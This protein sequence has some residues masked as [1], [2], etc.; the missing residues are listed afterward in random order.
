MLEAQGAHKSIC[1]ILQLGGHDGMDLTGA[2]LSS[3]RLRSL[4]HAA[5]DQSDRP[6]VFGTDKQVIMRFE[7]VQH[8]DELYL[9]HI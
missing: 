2:A 8:S 6:E 3:G 5:A 9:R 4:L 7:L 1:D